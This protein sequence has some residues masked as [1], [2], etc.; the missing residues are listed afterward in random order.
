[1]SPDSSAKQ[2]QELVLCFHFSF[3]FTYKQKKL[4]TT[5]SKIKTCIYCKYNLFPNCMWHMGSCRWKLPWEADLISSE[6]LLEQVRRFQ[7][8]NIFYFT[9]AGRS[10]EN[11]QQT[12]SSRYHCRNDVKEEY[13][14]FV[15]TPRG[16]RIKKKYSYFFV[17][18]NLGTLRIHSHP[19]QYCCS[20]FMPWNIRIYG[21]RKKVTH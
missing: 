16:W 15:Q 17:A 20:K 8:N 13:S 21:I 3:I 19:H 4:G 2:F 14:N 9:S 18:H 6:L 10:K 12:P 5:G 7:Y 1:M 11:L